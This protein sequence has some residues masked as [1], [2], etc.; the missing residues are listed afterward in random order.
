LT[1]GQNFR[2]DHW[3]GVLKAEDR[4]QNGA[5][6]QA[7]AI[8]D[9]LLG[10]NESVA[11]RFVSARA[12][13]TVGEHELALASARIL[14]QRRGKAY[15]ELLGSQS[16]LPLNVMMSN[17][18]HCLATIAAREHR[19]RNVAETEHSLLQSAF[20]RTGSSLPVEKLVT[21]TCSRFP[22]ALPAV[23]AQEFEP[24]VT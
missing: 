5:S 14:Y 24:H 11:A 21:K 23:A 17:F 18:G 19:A 13:L 12:Q 3:L 15:T 10:P 20:S 6:E 9:Q 1:T 2:I 4:L 16:M 22:R 8:S 7:R